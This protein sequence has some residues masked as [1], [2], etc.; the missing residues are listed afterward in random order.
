MAAEDEYLRRV[1]E[2]VCHDAGLESLSQGLGRLLAD[3]AHAAMLTQRAL[4]VVRDRTNHYLAQVKASAQIIRFL[5]VTL[6]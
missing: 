2:A 6:F 3:Q 5:F 1:S 4:D